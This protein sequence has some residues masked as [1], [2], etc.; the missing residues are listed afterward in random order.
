MN[1]SAVIRAAIL[2][3]CLWGGATG[4][5]AQVVVGQDGKDVVYLPTPPDLVKQM[6]DMAAVTPQDYVIDLGSG[7]GRIVIAAAKRGARALGIEYDVPLVEL[8]RQNALREM[9]GDRATFL[10]ADLFETDFSEATV[11]TMF[12]L[13]D[14]MDKLR[15]RLFDMK[16]GTRLVSNSFLMDDWPPDETVKLPG[17]TT[18]C[19]AHLWVVPA[20]VAGTWELPQGVLTLAQKYQDLSGTLTS[21][22]QPVPLFYGQVRGNEITFTAAG[23][24]YTGR[25]IG[26]RMNGTVEVNDTTSSWTATRK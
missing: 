11:L 9:V 10:Q 22:G 26:T 13:S 19:T 4:V 2:G 8:S 16:P 3:I 12:L 7:D 24:K 1:G 20:K 25:L 14:M 18:W 23:A 6:L 17:C 21:D 15:P 5:V